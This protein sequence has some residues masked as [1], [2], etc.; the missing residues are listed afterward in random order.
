[1]F[2]RIQ[3]HYR[4]YKVKKKIKK[5]L[6]NRDALF[7]NLIDYCTF[8]CHVYENFQIPKYDNYYCKEIHYN[9]ILITYIMQFSIPMQDEFIDRV[10]LIY[11]TDEPD[12]LNIKMQGRSKYDEI[13]YDLYIERDK[14]FLYTDELKKKI[15]IYIIDNMGQVINIALK[16]ILNK[17]TFQ[18]K[19][20]PNEQEEV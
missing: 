18:R 19:E 20:K 6:S 7:E 10:M 3:T 4:V 9:N 13:I 1:M 17:Y 11:K 16:D 12:R 14:L 15:I 5:K 8:M 2:K